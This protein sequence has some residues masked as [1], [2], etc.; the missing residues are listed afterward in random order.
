MKY[1]LDTNVCIRFLNGRSIS[2]KE[3]ID[4][5][6]PSSIFISSV[7]R[8]EL[9]YGA[10]KRNKPEET[11][12]TL[13]GFL[14]NF[15]DLPYDRNA[16]IRYGIIRALQII[17]FI[18]WGSHAASCWLAPAL[19]SCQS[20]FVVSLIY[21]AKTFLHYPLSLWESHREASLRGKG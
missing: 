9:E 10:R 6:D 15:P 21:L 7:V 4:S 11:M 18:S 14:S 16:A 19:A 17:K 13:Q 3:K 8:G 1:L 12:K 20:Y 5:I 2:I